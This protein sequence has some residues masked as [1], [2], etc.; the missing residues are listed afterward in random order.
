[1]SITHPSDLGAPGVPKGLDSV[2]LVV[3]LGLLVL[4]TGQWNVALA[5]GMAP[6]FLRGA[7]YGL[8]I[9]ERVAAA[10]STTAR[11]WLVGLR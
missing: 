7:C 8:S 5:A 6:L 2:C 10:L 11:R 9:V 3:A 4:T 1:M